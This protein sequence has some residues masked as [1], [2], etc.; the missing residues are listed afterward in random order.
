[1]LFFKHIA[2]FTAIAG[3]TLF[4]QAAAQYDVDVPHNEVSVENRDGITTFNGPEGVGFTTV[5]G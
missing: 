1:M 3:F 2:V 5:P 4:Q